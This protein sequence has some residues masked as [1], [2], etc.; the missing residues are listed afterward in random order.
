[1][2]LS[3]W[4]KRTRLLEDASPIPFVHLVLDKVAEHNSHH[5]GSPVVNLSEVLIGVTNCFLPWYKLFRVT[6]PGK[7]PADIE[8]LRVISL[9]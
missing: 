3:N 8:T 1:M 5:L 6:R 7:T 2:F 9:R 4:L